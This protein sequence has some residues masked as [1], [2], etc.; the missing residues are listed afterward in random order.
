MTW[1]LSTRIGRAVAGL[2]ALLVAVLTFGAFRERK[3]RKEAVDD[4][5]D[6]LQEADNAE[7]THIRRRAAAANE[8]HDDSG[9]GFRD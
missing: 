7:A 2:A 5:T 1:L 6:K 9:R 8:L 3:G 4:I